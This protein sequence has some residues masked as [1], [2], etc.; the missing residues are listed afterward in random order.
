MRY[1]SDRVISFSLMINNIDR[2]IQFIPVTRGGSIYVTD[3]KE[4]I[5]AL[6]NSPMFG[7]VY[8]RSE[9]QEC[10]KA[11]EQ[12]CSKAE[13]GKSKSGRKTGNRF[14]KEQ[15]VKGVDTWQ[16][17]I[18]YMVDQCGSDREAMTTPDEI[19]KEAQRLNL[20]FPNIGQK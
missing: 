11:E 9:E 15:P 4:E 1:V 17:A 6:E 7:N 14:K 12:D 13:D 8:V 19:L 18:E 2:R 5:E 3:N 16:G 10:S 20:S